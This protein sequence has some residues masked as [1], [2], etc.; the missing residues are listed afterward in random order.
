G[1]IPWDDDVD[2][3]MPRKDYEQFLSHSSEVFKEPFSVN[4]YDRTPG[5]HYSFAR[6]N[7]SRMHV[8]NHSASNPRR[9]EISIDIFPVDGFP[10]PGIRR[11]LHKLHLSFWW[12]LNQIVL[13][14]ELV[15]KTR[16]RKWTGRLFVSIAGLFKWIGKLMNPTTCLR[17]VNQVLAK[18]DYDSDSKDIINF[19]AAFGFSEVFPRSSFGEGAVYPFEG[20]SLMGPVDYDTV[21]KIIYGDYM[22]LPPENERNWHNTEIVD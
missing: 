22:T 11:S 20:E 2:V 4:L 3:A 17:H 8:I 9:E 5:Y 7:D 12:N 15:N 14:D 21:C 1:F 18:Y 10:D 13:Y 19:L 16:K 6:I